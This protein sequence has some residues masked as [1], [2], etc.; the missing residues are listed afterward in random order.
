MAGSGPGGKSLSASTRPDGSTRVMR[1]LFCSAR[2]RTLSSQVARV[3]R[4]RLADQS[5]FALE[6]ALDVADQVAPERPLRGEEQHRHRQDE[7]QERA[8]DEAGGESHRVRTP[9]SVPL[10]R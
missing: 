7:N 5:G 2:R 10:N 1:R 3:V 8:R 9:R 4:E 6:R